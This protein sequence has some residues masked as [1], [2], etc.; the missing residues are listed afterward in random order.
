MVNDILPMKC[1]LEAKDK[2]ILCLKLSRKRLR[3]T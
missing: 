2:Q 3:F 1:G